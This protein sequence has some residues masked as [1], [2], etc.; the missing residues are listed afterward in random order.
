M[1]IPSSLSFVDCFFFGGGGVFLVNIQKY[2]LASEVID[3]NNFEKTIYR[4]WNFSFLEAFRT[5]HRCY[6][7]YLIF[8]K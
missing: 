5:V 4:D 2:F 1:S 7:E 8:Y 3:D 6:H